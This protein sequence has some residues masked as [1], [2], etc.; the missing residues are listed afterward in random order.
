MDRDAMQDYI[1]KKEFENM[2]M[3]KCELLSIERTRHKRFS[4]LRKLKEHTGLAVAF[5]KRSQWIEAQIEHD[6]NYFDFGY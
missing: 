2:L 4:K 6:I 5:L 3:Q 1:K